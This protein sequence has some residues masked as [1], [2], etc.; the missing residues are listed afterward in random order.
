MQRSGILA[1]L[2]VACVLA[3]GTAA[4]NGLHVDARLPGPVPV[5]AHPD[6]IERL[7]RAEVSRLHET[8]LGVSSDKDATGRF[9]LRH[10][11]RMRLD[12]STG[13]KALGTGSCLVILW[14]FTDHPADEVNHSGADFQVMLF[15]V[16]THPTGS[17]NDF[18][19]EASYG[20]FSV[21]GVVEGWHT[22]ANTYASYA[23]PDGSQDPYTAREMIIDAI[24]LLDPIV[25]FS[26]YD[27]DG[28]DGI[29]NSGDDDGDI[30]ALFFVHAGPGQESTGDPEDI[31]SHAWSFWNRLQTN[32][33]VA[34][35]RYSVEPEADP[36]GNM[37]TIGVFAH[38]YGHVLG[39][40]DLYDTDYSSNGIGEWGLMSGGS[41]NNR[42][43]DLAG[44][45]PAHP[46]AWS[47][48]KLGWISPVEITTTTTGVSIPP[49]DENAV[50]YKVFRGGDTSGGE[51]FLLETRRAAGFD[52][53][54]TRRQVV[55]G[56]PQP[57]GLMVYHV[58]DNVSGNS[59]DKHRLV[60]VVEASPWYSDTQG[61]YEQLDLPR[62]PAGSLNL[63]RANRGDNG[64]VW[65]GFT[66]FTADSTDWVLPRDRDRF[67][68]D[69]VP[70]AE[71]FDCDPSGVVLENIALDVGGVMLDIVVNTPVV[72]IQVAAA[73]NFTWDFETDDAG[74]RY[75]NSYVHRDATQSGSCGG[76]G[77]LW[78]G[79]ND[80]GYVCPPGYGNSWDDFTWTTIAVGV[81]SSPSITL[82]HRYETEVAYDYCWVE[83]RPAGALDQPWTVLDTY[84]GTSGCTTSVL[85]IPAAVLQ[86]ADVDLDGVA[87]VD[88]RLR[89]TSD[90]GWS[91]EDGS[92]CGIGWWVDEVTIQ[93]ALP[94]PATQPPLAI[95]RLM[96]PA[97]NPFNP[98]TVLRFHIPGGAADV[99][100]VIYDA[101]GRQ[102][103]TL[104]VDAA[105][106][107]W[108]E[109]RWDGRNDRG[110]PLGSGLYFARLN[111]DGDTQI[112]KLALVK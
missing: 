13:A 65:P 94:T 81:A 52:A 56:L 43:G 105:V 33:G 38:E 92:Y 71:G 11:P 7:G 95:A 102:V 42:A 44:S 24:A 98:A 10:D 45:S 91:A 58:D 47:K 1:A 16:D 82:V 5:P 80:P 32:D 103:R 46:T 93:G 2:A 101:A 87:E 3:A 84:D 21:E 97:P 109:S 23:N 104:A 35:Y 67:A 63:K 9:D 31:W 25:D 20:Q 55:Y 54:L 107:G 51:Y 49:A 26:Q 64:D 57:E 72:N 17:M 61:W 41:W 110:Q 96:P 78:F 73:G 19:R 99:N 77:G 40:P 66:A 83:V 106:A 85:P 100:L 108:Q 27:N 112:Q 34:V 36:A 4:A 15:S 48:A 29:P 50:A 111:V 89:L 62:D 70:S 90:T 69:T 12:K 79:V 76:S 75:C 8:A 6:L 14:Q 18:F 22:A 30:D 68:D 88:L 74:W 86:A 37:M 53:G 28:P 59:S 39:L 60:D